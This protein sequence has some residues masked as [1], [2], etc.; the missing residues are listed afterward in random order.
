MCYSKHTASYRV[1]VYIITH[2]CLCIDPDDLGD[3]TLTQ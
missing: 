1:C 3:V 2:V